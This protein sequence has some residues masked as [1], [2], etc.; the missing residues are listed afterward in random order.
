VPELA[1]VETRDLRSREGITSFVL[2][3]TY[4]PAALHQEGAP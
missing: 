4:K 1:S 3:L 2:A